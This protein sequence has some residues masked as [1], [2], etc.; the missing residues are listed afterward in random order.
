MTRPQHVPTASS[1]IHP[2]YNHPSRAH[3]KCV[4]HIQTHPPH[5]GCIQTTSTSS[6][7]H[8][9]VVRPHPDPVQTTSTTSRT[10]PDDVHH[11]QNTSKV[12][13]PHPE[14]IQRAASCKTASPTITSSTTASSALAARSLETRPA[15]LVDK[16]AL[17]RRLGYRRGAS[18][19]VA[20]RLPSRKLSKR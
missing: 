13:A 20:S 12:R 5:F 7:T 2:N 17:S 16:L 19:W 6:R 18:D 11:I 9:N 14:C 4:H 1:R 8:P 15:A 3:P 10:H